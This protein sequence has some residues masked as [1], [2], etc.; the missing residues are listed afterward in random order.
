MCFV[1]NKGCL[2]LIPQHLRDFVQLLLHLRLMVL[3]PGD[4]P[5]QGSHL[6]KYLG[7]EWLQRMWRNRW[8]GWSRSGW[9]RWSGCSLFAAAVATAAVAAAVVAAAA[10]AATA[11]R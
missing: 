6:L 2:L 9:S 10:T 11:S 8:S 1:Y 5:C 7:Q 3:H 4:L